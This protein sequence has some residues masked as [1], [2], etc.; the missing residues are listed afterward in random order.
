MIYS[1]RKKIKHEGLKFL[2]IHLRL[3]R[4]FNAIKFTFSDYQKHN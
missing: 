4:F 1:P 2:N 3:I